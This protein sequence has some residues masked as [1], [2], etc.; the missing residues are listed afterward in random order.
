MTKEGVSA[1]SCSRSVIK[2]ASEQ[3]TWRVGDSHRLDPAKFGFAEAPTVAQARDRLI[4]ASPPRHT[5]TTSTSGL[6]LKLSSS[7]PKSRPHPHPDPSPTPSHPSPGAS[8]GASI[9][10][11]LP[12]NPARPLVPIR[13]GVQKPLKPGPKRQ[14]EVDEDFSNTKAPN[15]VAF[16]TFW[17][18]I[19]PY[20]RE[21]REDDLAMLGFKVSP[22]H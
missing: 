12:P 18:G 4:N 10:F 15:Q 5:H 22:H 19:E 14:S 7:H 11:S 20:L 21:V 6:K 17:G 2:K 9:D 3:P 16:T 1:L 8:F 13:P